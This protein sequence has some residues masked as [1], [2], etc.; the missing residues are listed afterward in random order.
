[1]PY[2]QL[3]PIRM[4]YYEAGLGPE[5]IV[6]VHGFQASGRIW[7]LVQERLPA[8]FHSI[9]V[10]NRGAGETTAPADEAAY[11]CKPFADDLFALVAHLGWHD[12]T[13]VGHS[14]GGGTVAQFAIEHPDLLKGLVLMN[15]IDPDGI[16][17]DGA[18]VEAAIE[19]RMELRRQQLQ[20]VEGISS[21]G[22][23]LDLP[24]P[25]RRALA[26]D[27]AAAPE[28]RLRGSYRSMATLRIGPQV[29]HLPMPVLL[30]GGD[31]DRLIPLEQ[32]LV[33]YTKLPE[34][35]GLHIWHGVGHSP[36]VECPDEVCTVLVRFIEETVPN[37]LAGTE[38]RNGRATS[39]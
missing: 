32:M 6:F 22:R 10:N 35:S 12:F 29:A 9:A 27:I 26:A 1:M 24:E 7:Q 21:L 14:M 4:H 30:M 31:Q 3:G 25:F 28:Q 39:R 8:R 36:N 33:T 11:G 38:R 15:P 13:L 16:L 17:P 2:A 23:P 37:R 20:T 19:R 34:G 5:R 18:D